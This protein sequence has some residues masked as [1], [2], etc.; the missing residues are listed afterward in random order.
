MLAG[1]EFFRE[2][3]LIEK[4]WSK[5]KQ[6]VR[7]IKARTHEDFFSGVGKALNLVTPR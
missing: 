1:D 5:V 7:G 6:L 4:M 2:A 3:Y